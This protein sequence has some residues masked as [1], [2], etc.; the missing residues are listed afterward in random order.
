MSGAICPAEGKAAGIVMPA[1]N[2]QAI[3]LHLKEI[4]FHAAPGAHAVVIL[5]QAR[6]HG[7]TEL[8]VPPNITLIPHPN[9]FPEFNLVQNVWQFMHDN[10]PSNRVFKSYDDIAD[11]CWLA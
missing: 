5:D 2:T 8:I 7:S 10:W 1:C 11:H 4:A 6:R 3:A 9:R